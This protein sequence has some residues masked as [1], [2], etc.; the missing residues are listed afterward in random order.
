MSP[1]YCCKEGAL[2]LFVYR[3]NVGEFYGLKSTCVAFY[4]F[5]RERDNAFDQR[6]KGI[7]RAHADIFAGADF[8]TA[9]SG[10]NTADFSKF[11]GVEFYAQTLTL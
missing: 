2:F 10:N 3:C 6:K 5:I 9:L 7:V 11:T 8:S 1:F 4:F